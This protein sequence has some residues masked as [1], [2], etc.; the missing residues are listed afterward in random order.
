M[1]DNDMAPINAWRVQ[2][3]ESGKTFW[4]SSAGTTYE[5]P[6]RSWD[7]RVNDFFYG[8]LPLESQM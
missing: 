4:E 3:D 2:R 8:L 7:Q 6:A 5:A 1:L